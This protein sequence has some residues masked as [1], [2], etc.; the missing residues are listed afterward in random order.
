MIK[1]WKYLF[2]NHDMSFE[3]DEYIKLIIHKLDGLEWFFVGG[4]V[5]DSLLGIQTNDIDITTTAKPEIIIERMK[6]LNV[7]TIGQRFGTIGVFIDKWKIEITTTREDFN[8]NG[9][10]TDVRFQVS[11]EEDCYRRDFT[12]NSLLYK[13]D[14]I[15]DYNNG[16]DDLLNHEIKF[17][18]NPQ[19]RVEEDYLRLIRYIRF[20]IRYGYN[21]VINDDIRELFHRNLEGLK[22]ISMERIINEIFGMCKC[23]NTKKAIELFNE[24]GI[25]LLLF[26]ENL[27]TLIDD[28]KNMFIKLS[29]VFRDYKNY[30]KL[31]L[32][33]K[34][35]QVVDIFNI[36][37][38]NYLDNICFLWYKKSQEIAKFY[39]E[40][41]IEHKN[42]SDYRKLLSHY[43]L[44]N[45]E[46]IQHII[47]PER[48]INELL[49]RKNYLLKIM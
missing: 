39:I 15:I 9:R 4:I 42:H 47:G 24:M 34:S 20:Y 25:S 19:N 45:N 44:I 28:N 30:N 18:G 2:K 14:Q 36:N 12:F 23:D 27:Y 11:F 35:K 7:I 40:Y 3:K 31:P 43:W 6:N 8:Q 41:L 5:R 32:P 49:I 48:S 29:L 17:I 26:G 46:S 1:S 33:K 38:G 37:K 22:H 16:I 13:N 21:T 10:H